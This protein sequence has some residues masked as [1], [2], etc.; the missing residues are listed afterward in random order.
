MEHRTAIKTAGNKEIGEGVNRVDGILKVTG[1]ANYAT[2]WPIKN[3]AHAS[4][5]K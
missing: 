5:V 4:I 1:A 3:H 2:D